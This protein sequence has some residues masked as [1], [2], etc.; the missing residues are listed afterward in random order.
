MHFTPR[1]RKYN[2]ITGCKIFFFTFAKKCKVRRSIIAV[3]FL[4]LPILARGQYVRLWNDSSRRLELNTDRLWSYNLYE[5]SRWGGGL[6]WQQ[7]LGPRRRLGAEGYAGYGMHD[8]K[9]KW[10]LLSNFEFRNT[11]SEGSRS[12]IR[13]LEFGIRLRYDLQPAASR[14]TATQSLWQPED[15][16]ALMNR[17]M[18]HVEQVALGFGV[19]NQTTGFRT[20]LCVSFEQKLFDGDGPLYP[21]SYYG[22]PLVRHTE[23]LLDYASGGFATS[24]TL[25]SREAVETCLPTSYLRLI[26]AYSH[27]L[28]LGPLEARLFLQGGISG[29]L[30]DRVPYTRMF[31]LGGTFG[32]PLYFTSTLL[33]AAP[34]EFT[35][36]LFGLAA[37]RLITAKPLYN[38]WDNTVRI[39]SAPRPFVA[40]T[41][42]WGTLWGS[43][44][45]GTLCHEGLG[46][47]A[48]ASGIAEPSAGVESLLRWGVV[49]IGGA[50]AFRLVPK[51]A[52]YWYPEASRNITF[53]MTATAHL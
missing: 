35:A 29:A 3:L 7:Q 6:R 39:G 16:T 45:D 30:G 8:R 48:P 2:K 13:N 4:L 20:E 24:L 15:Y 25:G 50:V 34:C 5:H 36:N 52:S 12:G 31:D 32:A 46:L 11:D 41:L 44:A 42:C 17:R 33:T 49:D 21:A 43:H 14:S 38:L 26:A 9:M 18:S 28:G 19:R 1:Q 22:Q 10:G 37:V 47:Q 51:N 53:M 40:A 27:R 23:L